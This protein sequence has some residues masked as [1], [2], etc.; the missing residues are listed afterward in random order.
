[1]S[2]EKRKQGFA[3]MDPERHRELSAKGGSQSGKTP[4]GFAAMTPERRKEISQRAALRSVEKRK[5]ETGRMDTGTAGVASG[6]S[7]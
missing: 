7:S 4:K 1:M 5:D 3:T 6:Q 2:S